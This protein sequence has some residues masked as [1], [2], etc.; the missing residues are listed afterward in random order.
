MC[1]CAAVL[2]HEKLPSNALLESQR[3]VIKH[4]QPHRGLLSCNTDV[5]ACCALQPFF[6]A[7]HRALKPGGV[8]CTQVR[9]LINPCCVLTL[10]YALPDMTAAEATLLRRQSATLAH[11]ACLQFTLSLQ[12]TRCLHNNLQAESLWLHL[13]IITE[14]ASMCHRV[15]EGGSVQYAYTT[16]PT[17]PRSPLAVL[18]RLVGCLLRWVHVAGGH[19][20]H[21]HMCTDAGWPEHCLS[22]IIGL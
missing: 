5:R 1:T 6:K 14:L 11:Q 13:P 3:K 8:V 15:F 2:D 19:S 21:W 7:M 16:I 12:F 9:T 4:L 17:Y 10:K 22:D 18:S 20:D